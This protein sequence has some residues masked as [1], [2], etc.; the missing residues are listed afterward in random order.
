M[1]HTYNTQVSHACHRHAL[2]HLWPGC[3]K[4]SLVNFGGSIHI[5]LLHA[6]LSKSPALLPRSVACWCG[7][8]SLILLG[9][10]SA[11]GVGRSLPACKT[12]LIPGWVGTSTIGCSCLLSRLGWRCIPRVSLWRCPCVLRRGSGS[13][14]PLWLRTLSVP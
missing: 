8:C 14:V 5:L 10:L 3:T 13:G 7:G 1:F 12:R 9:L 6:A 2:W 4:N 11:P